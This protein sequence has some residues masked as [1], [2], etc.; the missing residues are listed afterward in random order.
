MMPL[1]SIPDSPLSQDSSQG[2]PGVPSLSSP[3][4]KER[5][6]DEEE[7]FRPGSTSHDLEKSQEN[8]LSANHLTGL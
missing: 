5:S 8:G 7:A 4:R 2:R 1:F 3:Y 6:R